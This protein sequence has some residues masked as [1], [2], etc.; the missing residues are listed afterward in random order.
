MDC[1]AGPVLW[2][3][4]FHEARGDI[5]GVCEIA[6][7]LFVREHCGEGSGVEEDLYRL[8]FSIIRV[9]PFR[10]WNRPCYCSNQIVDETGVF[11]I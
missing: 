8:G 4:L 1:F 3:N 6:R 5:I 10:A 9:D 11:P 2:L 7:V